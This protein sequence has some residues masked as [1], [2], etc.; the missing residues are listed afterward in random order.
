MLAPL[1]RPQIIGSLYI[2]FPKLRNPSEQLKISHSLLSKHH[3]KIRRIIPV[4]L[5]TLQDAGGPHGHFPKVWN[6]DDHLQILL[7]LLSKHHNKKLRL[8][9]VPL[10]ISKNAWSLHVA[11]WRYWSM[12]RE[13]IMEC[14]A[15]LEVCLAFMECLTVWTTWN[16]DSLSLEQNMCMALTCSFPDDFWSFDLLDLFS[17][18]HENMLQW[19][20]L[21]SAWRS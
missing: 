19:S 9:P 17:V 5:W 21:F 6:L 10:L 7:N 8:S 20:V 13:R 2:H 1:S 16:D 15:S 3:N 14:S 18:Y 4:P 11:T 12:L